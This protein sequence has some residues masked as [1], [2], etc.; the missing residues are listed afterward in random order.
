MYRQFKYRLWLEN[1]VRK[2]DR[3][4]IITSMEGLAAYALRA[5]GAL[6][7]DVMIIGS[8]SGRSEDVVD[9]AVEARKFGIYVIAIT[10][11]QYSQNVTSAHPCGKR[12]FECADLVIDNCAPLG[13]GMM[14]IEGLDAKLCPASGLSGAFIM[15][16]ITAVV[17]EELL[18]KGLAPSAYKS[19]NF[20]GGYEYNAV[21][22][23]VYAESGY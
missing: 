13:D 22:Q 5:S 14:E 8:V 7:G 10:S 21:G 9:L 11:L 3:P 15:W 12:L 1:P 16:S 17:T 20:P 2:R 23:K 18:N 19:Y 4:G 6:P